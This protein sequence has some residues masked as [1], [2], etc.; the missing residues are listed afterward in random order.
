MYNYNI[1]YTTIIYLTLLYTIYNKDERENH[2]PPSIFTV[3]LV[4]L[5]RSHQ[6]HITT[7]TS[8]PHEAKPFVPYSLRLCLTTHSTLF[9]T[10]YPTTE[11][12]FVSLQQKRM[13]GWDE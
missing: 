2:Y 5:S 6:K 1:S 3:T 8:T 11:C 13:K 12:I 10:I 7:P 9:P 4:T